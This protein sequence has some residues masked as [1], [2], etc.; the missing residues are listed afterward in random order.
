MDQSA[1]IL[2]ILAY[3]LQQL[4]CCVWFHYQQRELQCTP[5]ERP[6]FSAEAQ[7]R[8]ER[9]RAI[10][11]QDPGPCRPELTCLVLIVD[12]LDDWSERIASAEFTR[13]PR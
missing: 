9:L 6:G 10:A 12:D 1:D 7:E 2:T 13:S 5:A 8:L 11:E 3:A 4:V